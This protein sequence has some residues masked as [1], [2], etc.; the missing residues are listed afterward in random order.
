MRPEI[1]P[2]V[3]GIFIKMFHVKSLYVLTNRPDLNNAYVGFMSV[4]SSYITFRSIRSTLTPGK[5]ENI[6]VVYDKA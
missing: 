3:A 6:K 4:F 2:A 1:Q 5:V